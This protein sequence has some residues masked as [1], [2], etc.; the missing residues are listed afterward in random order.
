MAKTNN[1]L[2]EQKPDKPL[3]VEQEENHFR[4]M[5]EHHGVVMLLIEPESGQI[6]DANPAAEKFYGYPRSVIRK[7]S[8]ND[9]NTMTPDQLAEERAR[10]MRG[11]RIYF[12]FRHRLSSGEIRIVES[13]ASPV[14][15]NGSLFL[16]S[17]IHDITER[18][19]SEEALQKSKERLQLALAA[20]AMGVWE[21]DIRTNSIFWSLECYKIFQIEHFGETVESLKQF[22]YPNDLARLKS[23]PRETLLEKMEQGIELPAISGDGAT[24]WVS[25]LAR[26]DYDENNQPLQVVGTIQDITERRRWVEA[27]VESEGRLQMALASSKMGVWEFDPV[28]DRLYLSPECQEILGT[29]DFNEHLDRFLQLIN[30]EHIAPVRNFIDAHRDHKLTHPYE[31]RILRPDGEMRWVSISGW[32]TYGGENEVPKKVGSLQDI[33]ERKQAEAALRESQERYRGLVDVSPDAILITHEDRIVFINQRGLEMFG[34][35]TPEQVIGKS[36]I[37]FFH[38]DDRVSMRDLIGNLMVQR[39]PGQSI[40]QR[41]ILQNGKTLPV[42]VFA[43]PLMDGN[44]LSIQMVIHD[45]TDR[46]RANEAIRKRA[47]ES[48]LLVEAGHELSTTL[49]L[50]KIYTVLDRYIK[51]L[52]PC[53]SLIVSSFDAQTN[54][55]HCEY[56]RDKNGENDVSS[57]PPLP[58]EPEEKGTQSRVIRSGKTLLLPHYL[59]AFNTASTKFYYNEDG[60]FFELPPDDLDEVGCSRSAILVPLLID[61]QVSGV[62]QILST[63]YEAHTEEHVRFVEALAFR[64]TSAM[65]NAVLFQRLQNELVE[66]RNA[67]DEVRKLNTQLEQRVLSRTADLSRANAEL[68]RAA[69]AKDE[70]LANMSHE[71]RTPLNAILT[72]SESLEEGIYGPLTDRQ[73]KPMQMVAESGQHLL[74]LINDVLDLSKIDAGKLVLQLE[75]V[76]ME[77]ICQA[78]LR[79]I[80]EQAMKKRLGVFLNIDPQVKLINADARYLKQMLVN[81]LSNAVKFTPEGGKIG[82]DVTGYTDR[83]QVEFTVWDTG[84][85]IAAEQMK[86]LFHPFVQVD[87]GLTRQYGGTG[88]GLALV[89]RMAELHGGSVSLQ[90]ELG[91]GSRFTIALSWSDQQNM[92]SDEPLPKAL[93]PSLENVATQPA[94]VPEKQMDGQ[95]SPL[96]LLVEDNLTNQETFYDYLNHIGFRV[97]VASNGLEAIDRA[98][99]YTPDLVLMDIQMPGMDG[100]EATRRLRMDPGLHAVPIIALTALAMAGDR[101]RCLDAGANDYLSKP[102]GLKQLAQVIERHLPVHP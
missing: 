27:L 96:I 101:E 77:P 13:F 73:H 93:S 64:V 81:L 99:E 41:I 23:M 69:R 94:T 8:I 67:E 63:Q 79:L 75:T 18:K 60:K 62:M 35:T 3:S 57:F 58:L 52:V 39:K 86:K 80:K 10:A 24:I 56:L 16:F 102:V 54:L 43:S 90:S 46:Q 34:A 22:L 85:G 15:L 72:F 55:I 95:P 83:S 88:L 66:R 84:I 21:W 59:E 89:Y 50:R 47:E 82:L 33:T 51:K 19:R 44:V 91:Q 65:S 6:I 36:A 29:V 32:T 26:T 74:N 71:L 70:F 38:P 1:N 48:A 4:L 9:I 98:H 7:M 40:E 97:I 42:E 28:A 11:D 61:G 100:L 76:E 53:D 20:S 45:I 17:I 31:F 5:F 49:D 30:P 92:K 14:S 25:I 78:S 12:V 37:E 87:A 2:N 68:E